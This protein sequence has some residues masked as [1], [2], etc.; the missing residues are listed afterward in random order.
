MRPHNV[1][2]SLRQKLS[3][4]QVALLF[5]LTVLCGIGLASGIAQSIEHEERE[6]E[7]KI[8]KHLP[9]KVKVKNV[10][11]VKNLKNAEWLRDVEIEVKNTGNKP[12]YYL[13]ISLFFIDVEAWPGERYGFPLRYGRPELIDFAETLKPEDI[14]IKPGDS[15]TFRVPVT[16]VKGWEHFKKKESKSHPKKIGI[17]FHVLNYGDGTGFNTTGGLPVPSKSSVE[18]RRYGRVPWL[19]AGK[20]GS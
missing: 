11:K 13:R 15:Y 12:I 3:V 20:D 2:P 17:D 14:P 5:L 6:I 8:P 10:E 19:R 1:L 16:F 4:I 9:I 18:L 7:D